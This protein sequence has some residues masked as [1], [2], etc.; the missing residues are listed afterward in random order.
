[1]KTVNYQLSYYSVLHATITDD[2]AFH[3]LCVAVCFQGAKITCFS[4]HDIS[5]RFRSQ[6]PCIFAILTTAGNK[7]IL[8]RKLNQL[9]A[10]MD[11]YD[12][13]VPYIYFLLLLF[14]ILAVLYNAGME[15]SNEDVLQRILQYRILKRIGYLN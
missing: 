12:L 9:S 11:S 10:L 7:Q 1:M 4:L 2:F 8:V 5:F 6:I 14:L 3:V 15:H 13:N